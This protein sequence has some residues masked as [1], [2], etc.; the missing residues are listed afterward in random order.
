MSK[1]RVITKEELKKAR[2]DKVD[3]IIV[4]G[5]LAKELKAAEKIRT[6]GP[7]AMATLTV[8]IATLLPSGGISAAVV[9]PIA[10]VTGVDVVAIIL[11]ASL[12]IGFIL[13]IFKEY[14]VIEFDGKEMKM[15]LERRKDKKV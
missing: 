4:E 10:A 6:I 5:N 13:A 8:F 7:V 12:G 9:A 15:K 11:A 14:E 3:I 2:K 1:R